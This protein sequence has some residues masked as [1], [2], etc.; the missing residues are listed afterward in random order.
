MYIEKIGNFKT[1]KELIFNFILIYILLG[2]K[3]IIE[4]NF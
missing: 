4:K 2:L 1:V 3:Y